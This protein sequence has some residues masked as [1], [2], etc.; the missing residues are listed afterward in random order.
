MIIRYR[1]VN[2]R[3]AGV[4]PDAEIGETKAE[5]VVVALVDAVEE[6]VLVDVPAAVNLEALQN[7]IELTLLIVLRNG[8]FTLRNS[9]KLASVAIRIHATS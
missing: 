8:N 9:V 2:V 6:H 7:R 4:A 3:V 1:I 5:A